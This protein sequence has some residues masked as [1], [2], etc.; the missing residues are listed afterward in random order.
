MDEISTAWVEYIMA[1]L[2]AGL[3][4]SAEQ[5]DDLERLV[6]ERLELAGPALEPQADDAEG[7]ES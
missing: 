3:P 1:R 6:S 5:I 4:L 2:R 7:G